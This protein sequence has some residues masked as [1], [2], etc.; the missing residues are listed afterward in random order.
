MFKKK[1]L[2]AFLCLFV[3]GSLSAKP[4]AKYVFYMIA[5]GVGLNAFELTDQYRRT[6][7]GDS[8]VTTSLPVRTHMVNYMADAVVSDSA[9]GGTALSIGYQSKRYYAGVDAQDR[10]HDS[11]LKVAHDNGYATGCITT[12]GINHATP[13]TFYAHNTSRFDFEGIATEFINSDFI[14]FAAGASINAA[15][16]D[17]DSTRR[18]VPRYRARLHEKGWTTTGDPALAARTTS[19]PVFLYYKDGTHMEVPYALDAEPGDVNLVTFMKAAID[20]LS[21]RKNGKFIIMCEGGKC[22][23]AAHAN[24][25]GN[26]VA[27]NYNFDQ[28]VRLAYEF[29]LKHPKETLIIVT[30]DHETGGVIY[31]HS[32]K[33]K[34]NI[35]NLKYQT[36]SK[37]DMTDEVR[38]LREACAPQV[39]TY[40]Q[41]RAIVDEGYSFGNGIDLTADDEAKLKA[42]YDKYF[43]SGEEVA[44]LYERNDK[45]VDEASQIVARKAN[46]IWAE[47]G[48]TASYIPFFSVG[49]GS[50]TFMGLHWNWEIPRQMSKIMK[51]DKDF[52]NK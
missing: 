4:A 48:H 47:S 15:P 50:E 29:Y 12:V 49:V 38:D 6:V 35:A 44:S 8:L 41:V 51:I 26:Y 36:K 19:T 42:C 43:T 20:N 17:V 10:P 9:A 40:E 13:A 30:S 28:C 32:G 1:I 7:Y 16:Y 21:A 46:I 37:S 22:D 5:D 39:P 3:A 11:I 27:E 45:I 31:G 24:D 18:S 33:P 14:D 52:I 34:Y 25:A 2:A 23:Y